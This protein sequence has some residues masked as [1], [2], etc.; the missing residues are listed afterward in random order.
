[1]IVQFL[2]SKMSD[3][4]TVMRCGSFHAFAEVEVRYVYK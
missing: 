2:T 4:G 1:M 3:E